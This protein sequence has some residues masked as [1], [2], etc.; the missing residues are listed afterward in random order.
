[1]VQS[2]TRRHQ[3]EIKKLAKSEEERLGEEIR[4]QRLLIHQLL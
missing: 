1:M 3:E 2:A 4:D